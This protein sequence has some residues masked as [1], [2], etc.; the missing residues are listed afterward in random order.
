MDRSTRLWP[1]YARVAFTGFLLNA[2][3]EF[4]QCVF[5]FDMSKWGFW[6]AS[7]WMWAAIAG[8][9]LIVVGVM[10]LV[11]LLFGVERLRPPDGRVWLGLLA[12]GFVVSIGLEWLALTLDLWTYSSRMPTLRIGGETVGLSPIVQIT[13]LPTMSVYLAHR[14]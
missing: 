7:L 2:G 6:R 5:L 10:G 12:S 8:D 9:V 3:W 13:V 1:P 14:S 4:F 11:S